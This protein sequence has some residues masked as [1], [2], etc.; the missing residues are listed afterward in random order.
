MPA[1]TIDDTKVED[2]YTKL[3]GLID[4]GEEHQALALL[5]TVENQSDRLT[6]LR[7]M[8]SALDRALDLD[9]DRAR[10]LALA[11]AR[12]LDPALD[13]ARA[14]DLAFAR[15]RARALD[16]DR[17]LA[18]ALAFDRDRDLALAYKRTQFLVRALEKE[19]GSKHVDADLVLLGSADLTADHLSHTVAP[20]LQAV[21]SLQRG[22]SELAGIDFIEPRISMISQNSPLG[23]EMSG[24][25]EAVGVI[26]DILVPW[27][28]KHAQKMAEIEEAKGELEIQRIRT[29]TSQKRVDVK[30]SDLTLEQKRIDLQK[31]RLELEEKRLSIELQNL[32][33][34]QLKVDMALSIIQRFSPDLP[35][36]E[37][38]AQV[39]KL[40]PSLNVL[41]ESPLE[42]QTDG[43]GS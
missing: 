17:A 6:T 4:A 40:L 15:A 32:E 34:Y 24:V 11:L 1:A 31:A 43:N 26:R 19:T 38:I 14:L 42:L 9:R 41:I 25:A 35:E 16:L 18:L 30:A 33:L 37:R 28:R 5:D 39:I 21:V 8:A 13:R 36:S 27:R 23:V 10:A 12:A 22:I 29:E 20:Y 7:Q 3:V 2:F